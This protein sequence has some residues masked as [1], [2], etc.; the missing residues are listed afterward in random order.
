[1][2]D[3]NVLWAFVAVESFLVVLLMVGLL[4]GLPRLPVIVTFVILSS[5]NS[6]I[7][8]MRVRATRSKQ[9]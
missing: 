4:A 1:M 3:K 9:P 8:V 7:F 5:I 2:L 6:V